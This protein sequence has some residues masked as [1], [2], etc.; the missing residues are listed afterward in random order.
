MTLAVDIAIVAILV[1]ALVT[2]LRTGLFS[3]LGL[4]VG[5]VAG[6]L[7]MPFVLPLVAQSVPDTAW[8]GTAV[9]S[10][11]I[12]LLLLTTW[13]GSTIGGAVRRG[14]DRLRLRAVERL[15]GGAL[16][17][18][19]AAVAV[20]LVGAGIAAAGIPR[21]SSAVASSTILRTMDRLTPPAVDEAIARLRSV[22]LDD[23][24]LPTIDGLFDGNFQF[25]DLPLEAVDTDNPALRE[26]AASVARISGVA[27]ACGTLPTGSGFVVADDLIVTNAHVVAGVDNPLVELPFEP[28]RDGVVVYFDPIGDLAVISADVNAKPL[29][30]DDSFGPGDVGVVQGYPYGG[31]FRTE[32]AGV[33]ATDSVLVPDIYGNSTAQRFVHRIEARVEPG[34]SGG[35]L[36]NESGSVAGVVFARGESDIGIGYA[37]TTDELLPVLD[38]IAS[39]PQPVQAGACIG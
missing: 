37:M 12:V 27:S 34:N 29:P 20:S 32:P 25:G 7:A 15:L 22:V 4:L 9:V 3:A 23:T 16:A 38:A 1:M 35:P 6:A 13:I 14:A 10:A 5:L 19:C 28:A 36:L 8:R 31:P 26:A 11:A 17:L 18:I 30:L 2:G 24:I 39:N 33:V 21:V